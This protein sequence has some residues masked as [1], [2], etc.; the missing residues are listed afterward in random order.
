MLTLFW[1]IFSTA[2]KPI[3]RFLPW[4]MW[5]QLGLDAFFF[6]LWIAAAGCSNLTYK[7]FSD[8]CPWFNNIDDLLDGTSLK[9]R[10]FRGLEKR[11]SNGSSSRSTYVSA[12]ARQGLDAMMVYISPIPSSQPSLN[13]PSIFFAVSLAY[14]GF[15]VYLWRKS[16]SSTIDHTAPPT[17]DAYYQGQ[18]AVEDQKYHGETIVREANTPSPQ[19]PQPVHQAEQ[20]RLHPGYAGQVQHHQGYTGYDNDAYYPERR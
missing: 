18:T 8:A 1:F 2:P 7:D 3:P 13:M 14:T 11:K 16:S 17:N 12:G 5:T 19:P 10:D 20:M 15:F 9:A 6:I 4:H